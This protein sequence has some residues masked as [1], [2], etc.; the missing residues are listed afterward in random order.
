VT[1][2]ISIYEKELEFVMLHEYLHHTYWV[3]FGK[4][5]PSLPDSKDGEPEF[6]SNLLE[7]IRR[8]CPDV[9]KARVDRFQVEVDKDVKAKANA[10]RL[11]D[12]LMEMKRYCSSRELQ[13]EL[14]KIIFNSYESQSSGGQEALPAT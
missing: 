11:Q 12:E 7:L 1:G 8:Y 14:M 4:R 6:S 9:S 2:E 3:V 10:R 13:M 5:E